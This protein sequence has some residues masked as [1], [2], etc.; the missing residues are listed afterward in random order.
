MTRTSGDT[1]Q[2]LILQITEDY[3]ILMEETTLNTVPNTWSVP[4][5][6]TRIKMLGKNRLS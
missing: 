2:R 4:K 6:F 5:G 1:N 3:Q